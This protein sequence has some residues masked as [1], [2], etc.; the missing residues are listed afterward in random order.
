M[1]AKRVDRVNNC[2]LLFDVVLSWGVHALKQHIITK[3]FLWLS[4]VIEGKVFDISEFAHTMNH[5][6]H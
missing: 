6:S 3:L 5:S 2:F 4:F 1:D